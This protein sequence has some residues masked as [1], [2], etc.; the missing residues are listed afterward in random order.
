MRG[1]WTKERNSLSA[2]S[3]AGI[4]TAHFNFK[5]VLCEHLRT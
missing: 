3:I 5:N 2:E 1:H 4:I